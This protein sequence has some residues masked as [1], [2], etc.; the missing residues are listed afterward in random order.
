LKGRGKHFSLYLIPIWCYNLFV[1]MP[2]AIPKLNLLMD[3][4]QVL[5]IPIDERQEKQFSRYC[6]TLAD[7]NQRVNLTSIVE[8]EAVQTIHFL[9]SLTVAG[10]LPEETLQGGRV[11]DIGAGAGFPGV[12]LK[13]A[14]PGIHLELLEATGK[15]VTFLNHLVDYLELS[16]VEVRLGRAEDLAKDPALREKFDAVLARG[17]AKMATLVELTLPF[18]RTGGLLVAHKKGD[19]TEELHD[20]TKAIRVVGGK[21]PIIKQVEVPGLTDDRVL[22]IVEKVSPTPSAFPRRAGMPTKQPISK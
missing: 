7:W 5:G 4:C 1:R 3:G 8:P 18:L 6:L 9:D 22:V 17:V 15:K 10:A 16:N 2:K 20:A 11:M 14:F 19:I 21:P 13:I 12:P